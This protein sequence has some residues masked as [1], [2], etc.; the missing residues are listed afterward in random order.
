MVSWNCVHVS[1]LSNKS[2][3]IALF[4]FKTVL[5]TFRKN[6]ILTPHSK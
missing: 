1:V 6:S 5:G 3:K 4:Y 2:N